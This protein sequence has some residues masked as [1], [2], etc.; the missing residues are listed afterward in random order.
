[1]SSAA[2][3]AYFSSAWAVAWRYLHNL[4]TKPAVFVPGLIF[5][6]FFLAAF[7]LQFM[8]HDHFCLKHVVDCIHASTSKVHLTTV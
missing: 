5:P 2:R 4:Y 1:M 7:A 3:R 8:A 6:L